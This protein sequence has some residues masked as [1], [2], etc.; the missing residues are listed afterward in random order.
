VSISAAQ[1][2]SVAAPAREQ[3]RT[4]IALRVAPAVPYARSSP[5][6]LS[7]AGARTEARVS[8]LSLTY[9]APSI[10]FGQ[11]ELEVTVAHFARTFWGRALSPRGTASHPVVYRVAADAS[12]RRL[13]PQAAEILKTKVSY[14]SPMSSPLAIACSDLDRDGINELALLGR[15]EI[16]IGT[17]SAAGFSIVARRSWNELSPVSGAPLR[18]PLG[19][20]ALTER[21]ILV[22]LSDRAAALELDR[23][24]AEVARIPRAFPLSGHQCAAFTTTGLNRQFA[25]CAQPSPK[26]SKVAIIDGSLAQAPGF[27]ALALGSLTQPNGLVTTYVAELPTGSAVANLQVLQTT[28]ATAQLSL[29]EVGGAIAWADLDGDDAMEF[30]SSRSTQKGDEDELRVHTI[31]P[32]GVTLRKKI[33]G[34][35]VHALA[36]CPF[37]SEN[38]LQLVA[39]VGAEIWLFK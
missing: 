25:V 34:G 23:N 39:A 37:S 6:A 31:G 20:L 10:A 8:G 21:G 2:K 5:Q 36:V 7:A 3:L 11:L 22:G 1:D 9:I 30:I 15:S 24:L 32:S 29:T 4:Q 14:P 18:A 26:P 33:Q 19:G 12:I 27:D 38:P 28:Q 35:P 16:L 17:V 13:F